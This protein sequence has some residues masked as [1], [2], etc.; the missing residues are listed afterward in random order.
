MHVYDAVVIGAGQAGLSASY[1]LRR[2]GIDHVSST[3]RRRPF[4]PI[5][6]PLA[7]SSC[8]GLGLD[9]SNGLANG[10][11]QFSTTS[12]LITWAFG[13]IANGLAAPVVEE[14][15]FRG[16]LLPRIS[17]LGA[18]APLVNTVLFSHYHFFSPFQLVS[19]IIQFLPVVYAAWWKHSIY[20]S[21]I[22]HV[23]GNLSGSVVPLL[24]ILGLFGAGS[25]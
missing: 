4:S 8:G 2:L 9:I 1:H 17:R 18:L 25:S 23:L 15:Y 20:V 5:P 6:V 11:A 13:V 24:L 22:V 10:F 7:T 16:Y 12:L 3:R 21:M 14:M 19:H